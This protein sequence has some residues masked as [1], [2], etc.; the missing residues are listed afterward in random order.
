MAEVHVLPGIER[1]DLLDPLPTAE[2]FSRALDAGVTDVVIVG[3]DR[4]GALY[5]ATSGR[6]ADRDVGALMRAVALIASSTIENDQIIE[7]DPPVN[8]AGA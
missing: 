3:R 2:L 7:T 1:R 5:V 6:D 4:T 8:P